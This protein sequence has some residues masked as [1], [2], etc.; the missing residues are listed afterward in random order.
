[1]VTRLMDILPVNIVTLDKGNTNWTD[2]I[3]VCMNILVYIAIYIFMYMCI[4]NIEDIV[5][6]QEGVHG[7][8]GG[9][10][11]TN[12]MYSYMKSSN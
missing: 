5:S 8:A 6:F 12:T 7:Y 2:Y 10:T 4:H 1:M 9:M 3:C 11:W